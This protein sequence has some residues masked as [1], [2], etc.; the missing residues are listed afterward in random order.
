MAVKRGAQ[1]SLIR[2]IDIK[3]R[4]AAE[5]TGHEA[6]GGGIPK[7]LSDVGARTHADSGIVP[8]HRL[9]ALRLDADGK[10][11]NIECGVVGLPIAERH[12]ALRRVPAPPGSSLRLDRLGSLD[13]A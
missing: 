6:D 13:C 10:G 1:R 12:N 7:S 11:R 3:H 5:F 9:L 4:D 2:R 8:Y